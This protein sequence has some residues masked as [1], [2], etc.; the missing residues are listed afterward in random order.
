MLNPELVH[1]MERIRE[2]KETTFTLSEDGI[3]LLEGKLWVPNDVDNDVPRSKRT[4][5][6][7]WNENGC[8]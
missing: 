1:I 6:V 7:E 5:L 2:G 8:G 4:F 3:L